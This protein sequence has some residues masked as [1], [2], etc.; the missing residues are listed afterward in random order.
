MA[1][2]D[3]GKTTTTERIL[4]Y[5]GRLHRM[6]EVHEGG[7]TMD[8]MEQE[9][10]RGITITSAATTCEWRDH[11]INIIDTPGHVDFTVEVERSL[12]V[13]DGAVALFC[14]VGGV[15]PQ[16]ETVW[17]QANRYKVPRIC[18]VNKMDRSGADFFRAVEMI[19]TNLHANPVPITIPMG[20]ADMFQGII[21]LVSFKS[22][23]WVEDSHGMHFEEFDV[24]KD[25]FDLA[26]HWR[27]KLL[28]SVAEFDDHLLEKFLAGEPLLKEEIMT[29][30]RKATISLK[31]FPVLCGA[32]F[33]NKG[34]QKLLDSIVEL[35]PSPLD[36][37]STN[38]INPNTEE[39]VKREPNV[40]EPFSALAFKIM[41]DPYVG[42]LT[43]VRVY[44]GKL[45]AGSA[46]YN[47]SRD[48]R[49][50]I[51]RI[52]RMFADKREEM[53]AVE[54]GDICAV[55]GLKDVRTGDTLCDP[56]SPI[57]L[58]KM[59]FPTPVIE[60][61]IEPKTRADQDKISEALGKLAEED[62]TFL[63]KFNEDTG[64]TVIA[65]MGELHL[66]ILVDRLMRE[67]KV[68]AVVGAPQVSY[69]ECIRQA[70]T[71]NHKF[72]KQSGGRGQYAHCV[73]NVEPGAPGS[74]LVFE[75]KI[76]GG[77]IPKEY[78]PALHKGMEDA[79]SNGP[80]AGYPIMDV[81]VELVDG[82]YHEVDS[83]EMAFKICG[84][85]AL[86]EAVQKG[87]PALMEPIM[88]VEV[89]TPDSYLGNVVGDINSRRGRIQD[90]HPRADGQV[91]NAMVPL[92][93]MFGYATSLRSLT[94]G[95]AIFSMQFDHFM[96]VPKS[97]SEKILEKR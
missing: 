73:I 46:V 39:E 66:E 23:V 5:T 4:F 68:E 63:V 70:C 74:G 90:M 45:D 19:R 89:V 79:M 77:A 33:K 62:P 82:S 32:S 28:E 78:I 64:Q 58:E 76:V 38:G 2:I 22:I 97:I 14:A 48:K 20:S 57:L 1:H 44:A 83:N 71:V 49:E 27:E 52:V 7:A 43:F 29:A 37:G 25:M 95:R 15:E 80:L 54:A 36:V 35:L 60:I 56:K 65:G 69:K 94:Q 24:P 53:Q 86:K 9:K 93:E 75:N 3:A 50:R 88:K 61:A 47:S 41:T 12:R 84:G 59:D 16:S 51:S 91:V 21:D 18:F 87:N 10:E 26:N 6:G 85:M 96:E 30:L 72:A 11:R 40:E 67:F 81:K 34:V 17:R 8:W 55:V 42:R 13:L 31:C 92:S